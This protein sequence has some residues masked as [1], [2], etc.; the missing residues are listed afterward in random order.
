M[1]DVKYCLA[2]GVCKEAVHAIKKAQE[3]GYCVIALDGDDNAAGL[4]VAD[5]GICVDIRDIAKVIE[6]IKAYKIE[7]IL[8]VPIGRWLLMTGM[9]NE[10]LGLPGVKEKSIENCIDKY[11]FHKILC[12]NSLR[13][14]KL[15]CLNTKND[16]ETVDFFPCIIKPRFGSGSNDVQEVKSREKLSEIVC[17][18]DFRKEFLIEEKFIGEEYGVDGAIIDGNVKVVL[19][20]KKINTNPPY[21]Q[22]VGYL[23]IPQYEEKLYRNVSKYIGKIIE[24]L[25]LNNTLFHADII[26]N[27]EEI[28]IIEMAPRPSGHNLHDV[29]TP[30]C[31]GVDMVEEYI[32]FVEGNKYKFDALNHKEQYLMHFWNFSDFLLLRP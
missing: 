28:S 11:K 17:G 29:F 23:E 2:I 27:D 12:E 22:C 31:T 20:R 30:I 16:V 6:V 9:V 10:K 1:S 24:S 19:L 21:C 13:N 5:I 14:N 26:V 15:I 8:P 18:L 25:K 7:F 3:K 32:N 4:S